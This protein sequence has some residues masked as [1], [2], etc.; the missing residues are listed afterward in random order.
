MKDKQTVFTAVILILI[1]FS[2]GYSQKGVLGIH[3]GYLNPKDAK[4]GLMVG[5]TFGTAIDEAVDIGVGFD[6]FHKAYSDASV[7]AQENQTGLTSKTYVTTVDYSRTIIPLNLIVN[8]KIPAGRY[9]GYFVHGG[10]GYQF[11]ISQEKNYE[12]DKEQTRKF[13]G[14]GWQGGAGLY[15]HVGRRSTFT[16]NLLYNSCEVSRGVEESTEGLPISERINLSGF[17]FRIGVLIDMK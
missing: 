6:V 10:I 11:L 7:V 3:A 1:T 4:G 17:G 14:L 2:Y 12:T 5:G 15:Y 8:V 13:G 9:L 16:L